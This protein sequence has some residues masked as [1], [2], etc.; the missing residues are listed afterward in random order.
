MTA[1]PKPLAADKALQEI[2]ALVKNAMPSDELID[3][4]RD[5]LA[6]TEEGGTGTKSLSRK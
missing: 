5:V 3:L 6:Q 4:I 2:K 1:T